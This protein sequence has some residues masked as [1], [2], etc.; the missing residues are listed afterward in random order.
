MIAESGNLGGVL[1]EYLSRQATESLREAGVNVIT[2]AKVF[3][4]LEITTKLWS[5]KYSFLSNSFDF[6]SI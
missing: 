2:N 3:F 4:S 5:M 6:L 1:P